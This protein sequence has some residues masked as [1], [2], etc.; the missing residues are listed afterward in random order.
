MHDFCLPSFLFFKNPSPSHSSGILSGCVSP[1][2]GPTFPRVGMCPWSSWWK[3]F[4]KNTV[5]TIQ[6]P[7]ILDWSYLRSSFP[8]GWM[9]LRMMPLWRKT[10]PKMAKKKERERQ[11]L[12]Q[13]LD[14]ASDLSV[15][16]IKPLFPLVRNG[17]ITCSRNSSWFHSWC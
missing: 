11:G 5:R 12:D 2:A 6:F 8:P 13:S 14:P 9:S 3:A 16:T 17:L 15:T 10:E 1:K 4:P 7:V